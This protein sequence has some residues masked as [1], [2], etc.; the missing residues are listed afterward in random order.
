MTIIRTLAFARR[1]RRHGL[2][3]IPIRNDGDRKRPALA[4][5]KPYQ[6][7]RVTPELLQGRRLSAS[8]VPARG[9]VA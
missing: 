9:L 1:Y 2:T 4:E 3:V 7:Q 5:W 8:T 6:E